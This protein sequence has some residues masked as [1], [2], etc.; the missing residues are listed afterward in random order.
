MSKFN[1]D[2]GPYSMHWAFITVSK[3]KISRLCVHSMKKKSGKS[4]E[5]LKLIN[6]MVLIRSK[7]EEILD[8]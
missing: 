7:F 1:L 4:L 2:Q 6:L 5:I 8:F 3:I